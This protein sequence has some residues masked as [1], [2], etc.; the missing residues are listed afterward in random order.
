MRDSRH[1]LFISDLHLS[2][3]SPRLLQ[4]FFKFLND[5]TP[6]C[7]ALY[8]LGDFFEFWLG[9]DLKDQCYADIVINL[10]KILN[11]GIPIYFMKGNRD[12]L[13]TRTVA[14]D[15]GVFLIDDPTVISIYGKKFL[16]THGDRL[17]SL[18]LAYQRYRRF[19]NLPWLQW[20][21]LKLP[22]KFRRSLAKKIHHTNPHGT[23]ALQLD[24]SKADATEIAIMTDITDYD[25][26]YIIHGHTHRIGVHWLYDKIRFVLGDWKIGYFNYLYVS[27]QQILLK[28]INELHD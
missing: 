17:C 2:A 5:I 16:L 10:K 11:K 8:I 18:D 19:A 26:D 9:A 12:F 14:K 7:E 27:Q 15:L 3:N 28:S 6:S 20:L 1:I 23:K 22:Q 24:Y 25:P 21:F 13:L 4:Y